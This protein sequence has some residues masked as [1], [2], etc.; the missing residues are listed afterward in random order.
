MQTSNYS[1]QYGENAGGMVNIVTKSGTNEFHGDAFEFVRNA[2]FNARNFYAALV[3]PLKRNQFGGT[4]GG[5][6]AIPGIYNGKNRTFVFF[7]YQGTRIRDTQNGVS[8]FVPTPAMING[9]FSALLQANNPGNPTGRVTQLKDPTT[10]QPVPGNI[11]SP[12]QLD[13]AALK[14]VTYL[15]ISQATPNGSVFYSTPLR[16]NFDEY[17]GRL[18]H[19]FGS[20]DTLAFREYHDA[21]YQAGIYLPGN[22]ISV[23]PDSPTVSNSMLAH[24]THIFRPNV[25]NDF[26]ASYARVWT[27]SDQPPGSSGPDG[28]RDLPSISSGSIPTIVHSHWLL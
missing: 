28:S 27:S 8:T 15:P 7:G 20:R 12:T 9:N 10:G 3:D 1:A 22:L 17:V 11:F 21:F 26:R 14:I 4:I 13:P 18:D 24:E 19:S 5:P 25:V 6:V 23:K 16:Q 2:E